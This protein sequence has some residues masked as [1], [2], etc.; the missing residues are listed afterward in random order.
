MYNSLVHKLF[1]ASAQYLVLEH[2]GSCNLD[3]HGLYTK[4]YTHECTQ[5][6]R[7]KY[8]F[9]IITPGLSTLTVKAPNT[10]SWERALS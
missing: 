10:Q 5:M 7:H 9:V 6:N 8:N 2:N 3:F 1:L 4:T